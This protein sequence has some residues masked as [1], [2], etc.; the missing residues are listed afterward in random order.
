MVKND[1]NDIQEDGILK[2]ETQP[3]VTVYRDIASAP[4]HAG[5]F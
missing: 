1:F 3:G 5:V 4:L 2:E